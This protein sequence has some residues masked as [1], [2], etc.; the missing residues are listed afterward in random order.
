[1]LSIIHPLRY[2]HVFSFVQFLYT[3]QHLNVST[4]AVQNWNFFFF[5]MML[6]SS[7]VMNTLK[8]FPRVGTVSH[9]RVQPTLTMARARFIASSMR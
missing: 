8:K 7:F 9:Q 3:C 6:Y 5:L 4:K 2:Y 1:M